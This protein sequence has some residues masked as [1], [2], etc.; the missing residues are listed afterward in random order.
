MHTSRS[1]LLL[2]FARRLPIYRYIHTYKYF[3]FDVHLKWH[4]RNSNKRPGIQGLAKS[5]SVHTYLVW[6][7]SNESR[8]CQWCTL[9]TH[10]HISATWFSNQNPNTVSSYSSH[11]IGV[12]AIKLYSFP[13]LR[14][15]SLMF[16]YTYATIRTFL[17]TKTHTFNKHII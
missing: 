8:F 4:P 13:N 12:Q 9:H 14:I 11:S 17:H 2:G 1:F 3:P 5:T 16:T 10:I 7:W 15:N 6:Y